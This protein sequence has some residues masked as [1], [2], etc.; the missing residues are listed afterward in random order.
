MDEGFVGRVE[1]FINHF[2]GQ[3]HLIITLGGDN[4]F[5]PH[6]DVRTEVKLVLDHHKSIVEK[7][8]STPKYVSFDFVSFISMKVIRCFADAAS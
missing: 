4:N 3:P 8:E 2:Y 6:N 5:N 1:P 7:V